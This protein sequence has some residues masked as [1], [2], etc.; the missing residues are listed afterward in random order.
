MINETNIMNV[1]KDDKEFIRTIMEL[2]PDKKNL[3]KGIIIGF[4][5]QLQ[6]KSKKQSAWAGGTERGGRDVLETDN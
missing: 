1:L 6:E 4:A 3:A 2:S 5:L